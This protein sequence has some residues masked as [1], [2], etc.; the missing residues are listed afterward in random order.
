ML[1]YLPYRT[2]AAVQA[3][4]KKEQLRHPRYRDIIHE[5]GMTQVNEPQEI[6]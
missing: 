6:T 1:G 4:T 5:L 3:D 2:I